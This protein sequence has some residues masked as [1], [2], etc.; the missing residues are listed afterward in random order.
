[1]TP[2]E[3][4]N[5]EFH[6][7]VGDGHRLYVHDWGNADAKIPI[8][9]LH[10][11]PGSGSKDGHKQLF[12]PKIQRVIFHDQRGCGKS[13]P[14]GSIEH[15][16]TDHLVNDIQKIADHLKLGKTIIVGSSWGSCLALAYAI[17]YHQKIKAMVIDGIV[18]NTKQE[19]EWLTG[20]A[21]KVFFPDVWQQYLDK[22][23]K[24]HHAKPSD[25]HFKRILGDDEQ[26]RLESAKAFMDMDLAIMKLDDR[27][28]PKVDETFDGINQKIEAHYFSNNCFMPDN[29]IRLH[30]SQIKVPVYLINGRYDMICPPRNA[31]ELHHLLPDS[32]LIWTISGHRNEHENWN[33]IRITVQ[34]LSQ[35]AP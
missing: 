28:T 15:N 23:P 18:T 5:Q 26:A 3:F 22:T 13:L 16:T 10:G 32:E 24:S 21:F 14:Y 19:T 9:F 2:D 8:I 27:Y 6:L 33:I 11:G 25:Y 30:A 12:D 35:G 1:M 29:Y 17:K 34:Q 4:T 31:Y 20:G 7:D